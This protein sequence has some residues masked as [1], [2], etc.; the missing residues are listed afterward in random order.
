MTKPF[1]VVFAG[2]PGS[3]KTI[4]A[5]FLSGSFG[6]PI[7]SNDTLRHEVKED[8]LVNNLVLKDDLLQRGINAPVALAEYERRLKERHSELLSTGR[9]IIFDGSVDRTWRGRRQRLE[10]HGYLHY[11]ISVELSKAFLENLYSATGRA[12]S[13]A[14]L[15]RYFAQHRLFLEEYDDD[16]SLQ[17]TDENFRDRLNVAANG[18][19]EFLQRINAHDRW[20]ATDGDRPPARARQ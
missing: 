12:S 9:S 5:S 20:A 7:F 18:L 2:V 3:S 4:I 19:R 14:Q 15:D 11:M 1:A 8:M 6:L 10:D 13:I 17:I 16:V